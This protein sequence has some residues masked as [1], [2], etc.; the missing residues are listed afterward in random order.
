MSSAISGFKMDLNSLGSLGIGIS[1]LIIR[2]GF[3][4]NDW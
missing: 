4:M 1:L 3:G 2:V